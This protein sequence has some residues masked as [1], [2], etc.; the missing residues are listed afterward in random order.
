MTIPHATLN[1]LARPQRTRFIHAVRFVKAWAEKE[2]VR[3][4]DVTTFGEA[5]IAKGVERKHTKTGNVCVGVAIAVEEPLRR[6][7]DND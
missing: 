1:Q 6:W 2:G 7:H 3:Y 5:M 4:G